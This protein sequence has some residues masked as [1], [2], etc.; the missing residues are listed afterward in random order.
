MP[1]IGIIDTAGIQEFITRRFKLTSMVMS[2]RIIEEFNTPGGLFC[3]T[4]ETARYIT[5]GG[6]NAIYYDTGNTNE[7]I[8]AIFRQVSLDLQRKGYPV[9]I[10]GV[11]CEQKDG[12]SLR[13]L[14]QTAF[15]ELETNKLT[16]Q[17]NLSLQLPGCARPE[18]TAEDKDKPKLDKY[19][20]AGYDM[21]KDFEYVVAESLP[22]DLT[23]HAEEF[24]LM[25]VVSIDMMQ[26]GR[27]FNKWMKSPDI[28]DKE[29]LETLPKIYDSIKNRWDNAWQQSI[30]HLAAC[31]GKTHKIYRNPKDKTRGI[32]PKLS[33]DGKRYLPCRHL[34]Q[35]GDDMMFV[36]DARLAFAL[37]SEI[38]KYLEEADD[39]VPEPYRKVTCSIGI[40]IADSHY[41]FRRAH[42][43]A[44]KI[45]NRA[46][47]MAYSLDS[48]SPPSMIDW[49]I[50][51]DASLTLP[52]PFY[53]GASQKPYLLNKS[54][55]SI[56]RS[57][58]SWP[59]MEN[60]QDSLQE[61]FADK[62]N[63]LKD[64]VSIAQQGENADEI[65]QL[66]KMPWNVNTDKNKESED[67]YRPLPEQYAPF[68]LETGYDY[69]GE[70]TPIIDIGEIFDIYYPLTV[71]ADSSDYEVT[72]QESLEEVN[73]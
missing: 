46:K 57:G 68:D 60:I 6:G 1:F 20:P 41:P 35:G 44:G 33:P 36:C 47:A 55:Y 66:L 15:H 43:L 30:D 72:E 48:E 16:Q 53:P 19:V 21:P 17:R 9:D 18:V 11:I 65:K 38:A 13:T 34:Y 67:T 3:E 70:S 45:R 42:D 58:I 69:S 25:A 54:E 52:E 7:N 64:M 40:M 50:N 4:H 32:T 14:F 28:T 73:A 8:K 56:Y 2:S 26:M 71:S 10:I 51:R 12:E 27:H 39:N 59:W 23:G 5:G 29:I 24:D 62:H 37:T 31:F 22:D 63:K 61:F 49:W